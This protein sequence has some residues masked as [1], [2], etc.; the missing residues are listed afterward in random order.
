M[1]A[2][3]AT[4]IA[5]NTL[6]QFV[7]KA[8]STVLGLM[9]LAIMTRYLG[10]NG[11]GEYTTVTNFLSFF[12][13]IADLG[14]TLVTVQMISAPN[15]DEEKILSNIF[16]L[17]LVSIIVLLALAPL[18]AIFTP[19]S[20]AVYLGIIIASLS[21]VFPALNQVLV[22]LF[23]K[24]L[25][26]DRV[27]IAENSGR[28]VLILGLILTE[29]LNGGLNGVL[30][31]SVISA[32]ITFLLHFIFAEKYVKI[33]L[34]FDRLIWKKI[35]SKSWPLTITIILNLLYLKTDTLVLS[36]I[37]SEN[38]VGLYGAAYKIIDVLSTLPFIFAG[39]ILP[40]LTAA[41]LE[42]KKDYFQKV[43]QR[44]F[45]LM[46]IFSLPIIA[47]TL[48]F[49]DQ[50]M[51][52][53]AGPNF[54]IAGQIL[55][56]L[57][58]AIGAIFLGVMFSHAVIAIDKQKKMIG[59]Y[60]F[61]SLSSVIG[62]LALIPRF[63]YYGAAAVTIYSELSI[64]ILAAVCV[65]RYA[66]FRPNLKVFKRAFLASVLTWLILSSL[67]TADYANWAGLILWGTAFLIIY[68]TILY[69]MK[70]VTL[71][72]FKILFNRKKND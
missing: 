42:N 34:V 13:I 38:D 21:F 66:S 61:V 28:V 47:G 22:G 36:L 6:L 2:K 64:A 24:K 39:I 30:W 50:V 71:E 5:H 25:R 1:P 18:V 60:V 16:S 49:A 14:L 48:L 70:G 17:R 59:A 11:F 35:F 15:S 52:L 51:V 57:I 62:Y 27:A 58:F 10:P 45:N 33:K 53:I 29:K 7:S 46:A 69:V 4:K 20:P 12:A 37:K 55:K 65:W 67:P 72:D 3:L 31:A 8:V 56:V 32:A 9:A 63:S 43:L 54:L 68:S 23:Q 40:I 44:S 19:Y 41:W 26:L